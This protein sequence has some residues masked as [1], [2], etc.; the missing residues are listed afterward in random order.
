[1]DKDLSE[2][3]NDPDLRRNTYFNEVRPPSLAVLV[4]NAVA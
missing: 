3:K 4:S 2:A 1:M